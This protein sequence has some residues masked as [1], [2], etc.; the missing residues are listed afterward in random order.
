MKWFIFPLFLVSITCYSQFY[1]D[2]YQIDFEDTFEVKRVVIDTISNPNNC[3]QIGSPAKNILSEAFSVPNVIITDTVN[4]YPVNDSSS[5]S[6]LHIA[7]IGFSHNVGVLS[8]HFKVD[9]DS[10]SDFGKIEFSPDHGSTWI[11]LLN[12]SSD[13]FFI[14]WGSPKPVLTGIGGWIYFE[15]HLGEVKYDIV[16]G[17]S[18]LFRFSFISDEIQNNRDGLMFDN[19]LIND[20]IE[21]VESSIYN[22]FSSTVFPN[23]GDQWLVISYEELHLQSADLDIIDGTGK[24]VRRLSGI[25]E[26]KVEIDISDYPP[27]SYFYRLVDQKSNL[28]SHGVFIVY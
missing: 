28:A 27:G 9:S 26:N 7:N 15:V 21:G 17:D 13:L 6:I 5:F 10:V 1:Y 12:D 23:P 4:P 19:L 18:L 3:W 25:V 20:Y 2:S 24:L 14:N 11:D 22:D 16:L 8:G